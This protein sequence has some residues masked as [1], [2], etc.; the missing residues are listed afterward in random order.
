MVAFR[1]YRPLPPMHNILR[2]TGALVVGAALAPTAFAASP[3]GVPATR[4]EVQVELCSPF[5]DIERLLKLRLDGDPFE[6]WLFDNDALTLFDRGVRV[7]LRTKGKHAELTV[8]I[9]NQDCA[10]ID[11][12][13]VPPKVGKC[14]Y[15]VHGAKLAGAVSL[16]RKLSDKE[17]TDLVAGRVAAADLLSAVQVAYLRDVAKVWPLPAQ[18]RPLGPKQAR[19][20]VMPDKSYEVDVSKLPTGELYVEMSHRVPAA[21]AKT[22]KDALD[23]MLARAG[24]TTCA[25]QAGQAANKLKLMLR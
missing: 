1:L 7:R 4:A 13:M 11:P 9:A 20:Y 3:S 22:A 23:A 19:A 25:D 16:S 5:P 14:E 6:V 8:K 18:L 17:W 24:V 10:R 2:L 21:D 12:K 15:D